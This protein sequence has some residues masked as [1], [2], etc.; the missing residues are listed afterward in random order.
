ML[1]VKSGVMWPTLNRCIMS[2]MKKMVESKIAMKMAEE[3]WLDK[4]GVDVEEEYL[5]FGRKTKYQMICPNYLVFV[6]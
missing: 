4:D 5:A 6:D 2:V 1:T 3:N